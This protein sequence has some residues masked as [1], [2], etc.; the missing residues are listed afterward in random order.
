MGLDFTDIKDQ[1]G[2]AVYLIHDGSM[3]S[4]GNMERLAQAVSGAT[5]KQVLVIAADDTT[6]RQIL[7]FYGL[8]AKNYVI[9]VRDDDQ[10]FQSWNETELPNA[11]QIAYAVEQIG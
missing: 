8:T 4:Q 2:A 11:D 7:E 10:L 9:I 1:P 5:S 6:G 3:T